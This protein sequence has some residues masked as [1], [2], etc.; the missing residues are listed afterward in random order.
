MSYPA[1]R[2]HILESIKEDSPFRLTRAI[3]RPALEL[4]ELGREW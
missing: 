2:V 4:Q 3:S 1:N